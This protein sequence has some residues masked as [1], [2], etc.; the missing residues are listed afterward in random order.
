MRFL[1]DIV[2]RIVLKVISYIE[3]IH[4][5]VHLHIE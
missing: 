3:V 4:I 1:K 5:F 2:F